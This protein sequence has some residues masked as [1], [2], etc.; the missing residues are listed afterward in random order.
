ME[1]DRNDS[2]YIKELLFHIFVFL[3][4]LIVLYSFLAISAM[5]EYG[6]VGFGK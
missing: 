4:A 2:E 5:S 6:D 3:A 1:N